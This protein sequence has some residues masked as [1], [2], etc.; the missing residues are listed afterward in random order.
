MRIVGKIGFVVVILHTEMDMTPAIPADLFKIRQSPS[1][2]I[3]SE[4]VA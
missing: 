4:P 1:V 2:E 3:P